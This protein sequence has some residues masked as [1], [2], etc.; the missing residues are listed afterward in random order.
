M[1]ENEQ[2]GAP[3][4]IIAA[5]LRRERGRAGLTLSEVARRA[6]VAKSTL[7][8]LEAGNGNPS[9]ETLWAL[10]VALDVPFSRL[11]DPPNR[12]IQVIRADEGLRVRSEQ[13]DFD[14]RLLSSC[15]PGAR[16]DVYTVTLQP[17]GVRMAEG[18]LPGTV[19]HLVVAAGALRAGPVDQVVELG[20]GDYLSF[21]G[22]VPHLYEATAIDTSIVL[23]ME[24]V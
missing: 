18:H 3:L 12:P 21:P 11:V 23:V 5:A 10:G 17:D 22:D 20:R 24:H 13:A 4:D 19:E 2:P 7:S 9:V 15:P 1:T 16:R 14:A 8:Q 6:G